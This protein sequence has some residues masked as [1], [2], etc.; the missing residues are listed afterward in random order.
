MDGKD[1]SDSAV[2][3]IVSDDGVGHHFPALAADDVAGSYLVVWRDARSD[4]KGDIYGQVVSAT[5]AVTGTD[6]VVS[7]MDSV[8]QT[9]P[10]LA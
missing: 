7:A 9:R 1:E 4:S 3:F 6:F 5:G 8:Y 2:A 10:D